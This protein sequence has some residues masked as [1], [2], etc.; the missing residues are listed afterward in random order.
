MTSDFIYFEVKKSR[1][2]TRPA[3]FIN[4]GTQ[5]HAPHDFP[6]LKQGPAKQALHQGQ[7]AEDNERNAYRKSQQGQDV[8]LCLPYV[9]LGTR[10]VWKMP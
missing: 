2:H 3:F 7:A 5:D 4:S 9:G 6:C 1:T 10:L 8:K